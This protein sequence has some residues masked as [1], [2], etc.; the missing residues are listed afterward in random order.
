MLSPVTA[1]RAEA[2]LQNV[3]QQVLECLRRAD[4]CAE[5]AKREPNPSLQQ[6]FLEMENRWLKLAR[7]YQFLEQLGLF[8]AHN[9][10]RRSELSRRLGQLNRF[11][12]KN[13]NFEP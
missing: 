13:G 7:S 2:M 4:D 9:N 6:D 3:N 5:R 12:G 11:L 10:Q 8:T 1:I